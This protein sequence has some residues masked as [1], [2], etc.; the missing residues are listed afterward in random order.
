MSGRDSPPTGV[1]ETE[2]AGVAPNRRTADRADAPVGGDRS[3]EDR[4][5]NARSGDQE[6]R[7][8]RASDRFLDTFVP[9]FQDYWNILACQ[10]A[11]VIIFCMSATLSAVALTYVFSERYESTATI[12][13][14]PQEVTRISGKDS[15]AFG[16][17]APAPPFKVISQTMQEVLQSSV[18]LGPVVKS[19]GLDIPAPKIYEGP[20]YIVY[21]KKTK[22]WVKEYGGN[23]WALLKHG[24]LIDKDTY[25][26]SIG[27][28]RGNVKITNRDSY[29]FLLRV[30]HKDRDRVADI[31]NAITAEMMKWLRDQETTP[32]ELKSV[33]LRQ[34][35]GKKELEIEALYTAVHGQLASVGVAS[36]EMATDRSTERLSELQL[37]RA[38]LIGEIAGKK[39]ALKSILG[40][41]KLRQD[42][43]RTPA[44]RRNKSKYIQ[45]EDARRLQSEQI[46]TKI[47]LDALMA[48][49]KSLDLE[50]A[51]LKN[52]LR[53]LPKIA[54]R[55]DHLQTNLQA[56]KRD[57]IQLKSTLQEEVIRAKLVLSELGVIHPAVA[58]THPVS[59]I[60]A[61]HAGLAAILSLV[62][63]VGLVYLLTFL[64]I[65]VLFPSKGVRGRRPGG[66]PG[67][68]APR[69][70]GNPAG[71]G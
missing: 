26:Q 18:I 23:A 63:A 33:Q 13:Y 71:G 55:V 19:L 31:V 58:P 17:P 42:I 53:E 62:F 65:R 44:G 60:K 59:P 43:G 30:R 24:R 16:A 41:S 54:L 64:E 35:I 10:K 15:Q 34:L 69:R 28:L 3:D 57:L 47:E 39:I 32:G 9:Q 66:A 25:R 20:W 1:Q 14:R 6:G 8:R 4:R 56:A 68:D 67:G 5:A 52:R 2:S 50:I 40:Q 46:F 36:I 48:Q 12:F 27:E 49:S 11:F 22:D 7:G 21:Y 61:Y 38:K 37:D 70:A 51:E 45:P 29:V